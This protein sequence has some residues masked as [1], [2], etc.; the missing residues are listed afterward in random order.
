MRNVI[1]LLLA[2]WWIAGLYG[3]LRA[4]WTV[5]GWPIDD[6]NF[7]CVVGLAL[8]AIVVIWANIY[9]RRLLRALPLDQR[10]AFVRASHDETAIW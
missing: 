4:V 2:G 5:F 6:I 3:L 8:F 9:R 10:E 7:F 1:W